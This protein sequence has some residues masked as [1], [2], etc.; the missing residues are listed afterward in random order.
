MLYTTRTLHDDDIIYYGRRPSF[1]AGDFKTDGCAGGSGGEKHRADES[2]CRR[3]HL[4]LQIGLQG[5]EVDHDDD[6]HRPP[7]LSPLLRRLGA[8]TACIIHN[9]ILLL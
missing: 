4:I 1:M 7:S 6:F 8:Q 9:M 3:I 2:P 5:C